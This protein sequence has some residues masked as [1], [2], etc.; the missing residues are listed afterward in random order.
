MFRLQYLLLGVLLFLTG[1]QHPQRNYH[2]SREFFGSEIH[3]TLYQ[4]DKATAQ[5]AFAILWEDFSYL[6]GMW[7]PW[8]PGSLSRTNTLLALNREFSASPSVLPLI[9][10]ARQL[11]AASSYLYNPATGK[12]AE[13]WGF[14]GKSAPTGPPPGAEQ[15][16]SLVAQNP[17]LDDIEI[18]GVRMR[19]INP[20]L[21]LD[22]GSLAKALAMERGIHTL[23]QI[24]I[25]N[26]QINADSDVKV[27]GRD[28]NRPWRVTI[29][30]PGDGNMLASVNIFDGESV[31][32]SSEA[33]HYFDYNGKRYHHI[34]DPRTGYPANGTTQVTIIHQDAATAAAAA[35]ALFVAGPQEWYATARRMRISHVILI[36]NQ[37]KIHMTPS[38]ATRIRFSKQAVEIETSPPL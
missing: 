30:D 20:A 32:T 29:T 13:L 24:G 12:L 23:H 7:H 14:Q 2:D 5:Q 15:I 35:T 37:G 27:M 9:E 33:D 11:S 31:F 34:L 36:D 19:G 4:T 8:Q 25:N 10:K 21:K 18:S 1:C 3:I 26:A 17:T 28:E 22:F 6:H 16:Q 38:M